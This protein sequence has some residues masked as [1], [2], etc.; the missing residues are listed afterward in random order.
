MFSRRMYSQMLSDT[1]LTMTGDLLG[2]LRYMSPE[3][4]LAQRVVVDHRTDIYSLGV[5][6]YELLTLEPAFTGLD[7][8]ELLRQIAFEEPKPPRRLDRS[9]P[10]ELETIVLKAMA[11]HPDERY[12]TARELADDL[13]RFLRDEPIR[14]RRP[15]LVQRT[16]KWARRHQGMVVTGGVSAAVLLI[17]AIVGLALTN[18][19]ISRENQ[20]TRD[21]LEREI[22]AK[23]TTMATY[24][25][26]V[27]DVLGSADPELA[28]GRKLTV[29]EALDNAAAT[30]DTAFPNRPLVEG[31][32]RHTLGVTYFHLGAYPKAELHLTRSL[33][34]GTLH[35]GRENLATLQT[36][37]ALA[38]VLEKRGKLREALPL[39]EETLA[40]QIKV[41]GPEHRETLAS[42]SN[43]G[44][45]LKELGRR[46]EAHKLW[47]ETYEARRR[48]LGPTDTATI[49]ATEYLGH[50]LVNQGRFR[51]A[52]KLHEETFEL[53][54]K[55]LGPEH[56][57]TLVSA[58]NLAALLKRQGELEKARQLH[59]KVLEVRIRVLGPKHPRTLRTRGALGDLLAAQGKLTPAREMLQEVLALET[60]VLGEEH[61]WTLDTMNDLAN[62]LV[63]LGSFD[64]GRK[65]YER[66]I[67]LRTEALGREHPD[68]LLALG[69][70][71]TMLKSRLKFPEARKLYEE[72]LE[73]S[74]RVLGQDHPTTLVMMA[75]LAG[76]LYE[77]KELEPAER[78]CRDALL[79]QQRVLGAKHPSVFHCMGNLALIR[80]AQGHGEEGRRLLQQTVDLQREV[81]GSEH[82]DTLQGMRLLAELLLERGAQD[83]SQ[84]PEARKQWQAIW[85]STARTLG[86]EHPETLTAKYR[87]ACTLHKMGEYESAARLMAEVL[88]AESRIL[89]AGHPTVLQTR[90]NLAL[91][92]TR[93]GKLEEASK[94]H[95]ENLKWSLEVHGPDHRDTLET[96]TLLAQLLNAL[97]AM[98][99]RSGKFTEADR[100]SKQALALIE[101]VVARFPTNKDYREDLAMVCA[102]RSRL[103]ANCPDPKLRELPEAVR[104]AKRAVELHPEQGNFWNALGLAH[105]RAEDYP[106]ALAALKKAMDLRKGGDAWDWFLLSMVH[107]R[108]GDKDQAHDRFDQAVQWMEKRQAK[109]AELRRL[110]TEAAELLGIK[111][112]QP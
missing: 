71:A 89:G 80:S 73:L 7:R 40:L 32:V 84:L 15:T 95:E 57:E 4:A 12:D 55:Q 85:E 82:H 104:L 41:L 27:R 109:Q 68:T 10:A 110:R 14:A 52:R 22:L 56:P 8:R 13:G 88:A 3:Q 58:H 93:F 39:Q 79:R 83:P 36:M 6:L 63:T 28:L 96:T 9:I 76:V 23:A 17:A 21:A 37:Y 74:Q 19:A 66:I 77:L 31:A 78:L 44:V 105:Y 59:E 91:T 45:I 43:L 42:K 90:H 92:L 65:L 54:S 51:E 60:E 48:T 5:T 20:E 29:V 62:V 64:E 38:V 103:L 1:R 11:K 30:I 94:L 46:D 2:T 81:L 108:L 100:A 49:K 24:Q 87:L 107:W 16:R 97:G 18:A 25:Y 67:A 69:N 50:A 70:L 106:A 75:N 26:L 101:P 53:L 86:P 98:A 112:N 99:M 61:P 35:L 111:E 102:N 72:V 47:Q 34:L 33:K